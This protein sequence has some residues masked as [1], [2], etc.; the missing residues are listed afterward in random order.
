MYQSVRIASLVFASVVVVGCGNN[1]NDKRRSDNRWAKELADF[2]KAILARPDIA[3]VEQANRERILRLKEQGELLRNVKTEVDAQAALA[4]VDKNLILHVSMR[5]LSIGSEEDRERLL[6]LPDKD[7][8]MQEAS[9]AM[10]SLKLMGAFEAS[11][12]EDVRK[13]AATVADEAKRVAE[14]HPKVFQSIRI[15]SR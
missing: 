8:G 2:D 3:K 4:Q 6:Y 12:F 13:A 10:K 14:D 7:K 1:D 15:Q 5:T 11:T 9:E